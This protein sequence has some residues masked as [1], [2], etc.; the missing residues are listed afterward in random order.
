MIRNPIDVATRVS[1]NLSTLIENR[2]N[3]AE[4][5]QEVTLATV[6]EF[7][8]GLLNEAFTETE[9]LHHFD[10]NDSLLDELDALIESY[11]REIGITPRSGSR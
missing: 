11:R 10:I 7:L 9:H 1:P 8:T 2:V 4:P 3:R 5:G 6:R